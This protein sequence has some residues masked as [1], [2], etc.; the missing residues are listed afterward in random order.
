M[1]P[2][3]MPTIERRT[4][5]LG[6]RKRGPIKRLPV[7]ETMFE[8]EGDPLEA[9]DY[10]IPDLEQTAD[11]EMSEILRQLKERRKA[12]GDRFRVARDP[13]YFLVLCFQSQEQRN[14]FLAKSG[15]GP[16]DAKY[17]NGLEIARRLG[18]DVAPIE[19]KP[20]P[21]RGKSHKFSESEVL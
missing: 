15:W 12:Q 19:I 3:P 10:D 8:D 18:L 21:F 17:M 16:A 13:E 1:S 6:G 2:K 5:T 11:A 7:L 14:E 4:T 20:L 9:V